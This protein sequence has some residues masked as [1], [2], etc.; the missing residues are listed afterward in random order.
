MAA[1]TDHGLKN[2]LWQKIKEN[3]IDDHKKP[4]EWRILILDHFTTKV[5]S[6]CCKMSDLM[7]EGITI[8]EDLYKNREPVPEMKAVY[9]ISPSEKGVD[10]LVNDF[11]STY[12]YK[13]AYIYFTDYCPDSL[14]NKLRTYCAKAI[15]VCK[16]LNISFLPYESQV[17]TLDNPDAFHSIYSTHRTDKDT[18]LEKMA[19]QIVTLCATLDENPGVRYKK[20]PLDNAK[21]LAQLVENKLGEH[22]ELDEKCKGKSK[23]Q[24]QLLIV[25]RGFDP[26]SPILHELTYQAMVYDLIS[27]ENDTY[28]YQSKDGASAKEKQSILNEEDDL[29]TKLRHMHIA[30]VSEEIPKRVKEISANKKIKDGKITMSG[31]S[32]LMKKMPSFRKQISKKTVHLNL[33]EECMNHFQANVEK[34]CKVEQDLALGADTE[35]QKVKDPMRTLLPVLLQKH[36]TYDKIRAVL[37]YIFSLN[38]TTEENLRKI[39]QQIDNESNIILNWDRLGV[40]IHS[41]SSQQRKTARKD[42]SHEETYQLSRWTPVIKDVMEDAIENKLETREWPH[43]SECPAA[44]NGSGAVSARQKHKGSNQDDRRSGSRLIVF[45]IGGVSYSEMRCAYEVTQAVKSCEVIIGS[46]HILTPRRLLD[47]MQDLSKTKGPMETFTIIEE[48]AA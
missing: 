8:V 40:P 37:L 35:G 39:F 10:S 36:S 4:G 27:I 23:T 41:S 2:I 32:Q 45:I 29:W 38:G 43:K 20:E 1:G 21:K 48:K 24:A 7:S 33:A 5:L 31:L 30:E 19:E 14:F 16:E 9:F 47:D 18:T 42:R 46:T 22:Y 17:F 28:K 15:R 6:S 13:A 3:V 26:V 34:L 12:K 44:W 25:D 11:K